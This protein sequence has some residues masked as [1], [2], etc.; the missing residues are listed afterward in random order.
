MIFFDLTWTTMSHIGLGQQLSG[1]A[2]M[3]YI[4]TLPFHCR[5]TLDSLS[6]PA[7][8]FDLW[9][10]LVSWWATRWSTISTGPPSLAR[11]TTA[12]RELSRPS[13]SPII[14]LLYWAR[15]PKNVHSF[16]FGGSR[17][18]K[19]VFSLQLLELLVGLHFLPSLL[20]LTGCTKI[21]VKTLICFCLQIFVFS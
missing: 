7:L 3:Q 13:A 2:M 8:E 11:A 14:L 4:P 5:R 16:N 20:V 10:R 9:C 1:L 15:K 12:P 17:H 6:V 19:M 18:S 21:T